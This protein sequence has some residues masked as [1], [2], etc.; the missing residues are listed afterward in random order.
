MKIRVENLGYIHSGEVNL[1][2]NLTVFIGKNQTGK[3][4][5]TYTLFSLF[6]YSNFP[7]P[8]SIFRAYV[9][10]MME[11]DFCQ[12]ALEDFLEN[13]L[14]AI[15][16]ALSDQLTASL[17]Q[18]F[19]LPEKFFEETRISIEENFNIDNIKAGY[20]IARQERRFMDPVVT[21]S[22]SK[23]DETDQL[24]LN[25]SLT[26]KML[27]EE[28]VKPYLQNYF[29]RV[30]QILM[31][32]TPYF[33]VAERSAFNLFLNEF[34]LI[35]G[36]KIDRKGRKRVDL[37]NNNI[38]NIIQQLPYPHI[39]YLFNLNRGRKTGTG[40]P[41]ASKYLE[42]MVLEGQVIQDETGS[43]TFET[44]VKK[45]EHSL[46]I[47]LKA[48]AS[49]VKSL[50]HFNVL[51]REQLSPGNVLFID[52]PEINLHPDNQ[53]HLARVIAM[54]ANAGVK[55]VVSTHSL[56][57]IQEL[58]NLMMLAQLEEST[59]KTSIMNQCGY[60]PEMELAPNRVRA[61]LFD[62]NKI[63]NLDVSETGIGMQAL[64]TILGDLNRITRRL[65]AELQKQEPTNDDE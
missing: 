39:D 41:H 17:G 63:K 58:N 9:D 15:N 62:E 35:L 23:N 14:E 34:R 7:L 6:G 36:G 21:L 64:N 18:F 4:Y 59:E 29:S 5:L 2:R 8:S 48:T 57:F 25:F 61:Y 13:H 27:R 19:A 16:K 38:D 10:S 22:F 54:L 44:R 52:E 49:L 42:Q 40:I 60:L 65:F 46:S 43:F 12:I 30:L 33:S 55:V 26:R 1:D 28:Q 56:T 51:V 11:T 50:A 53:Y 31:F 37:S 47:P 45:G 32:P 24:L 3:T 20:E